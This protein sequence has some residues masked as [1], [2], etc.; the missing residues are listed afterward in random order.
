MIQ[1]FRK[2][3]SKI[4]VD[5]GSSLNKLITLKRLREETHD[6]IFQR[7]NMSKIPGENGSSLNTTITLKINVLA[8]ITVTKTSVSVV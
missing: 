7:K 5:N 2:N 1:Y 6:T 4:P 3:M 8:N